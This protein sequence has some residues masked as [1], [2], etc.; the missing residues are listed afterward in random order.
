MNI[1]I[2]KTGLFAHVRRLSISLLACSTIVIP[3]PH[4]A[5]GPI[6]PAI[7]SAGVALN[8]PCIPHWP[9][10][11]ADFTTISKTRL[12][13]VVNEK[14][15]VSQSKLDA[16]SG[17]SALDDAVL[18]A[19]AKCKFAPVVQEGV[20]VKHSFLIRHTWVPGQTPAPLRARATC[21]KPRYPEAAR[22]RDQQGT[23][24]MM[25]LISSDGSV[26]DAKITQSSGFPLLDE[27]A[28]SSIARCPFEAGMTDGKPEQ[29]WVKLQYVWTLQ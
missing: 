2:I 25:F 29:S 9:A 1:R 22:R 21:E 6:D 5:A 26:Q 20:P 14:G 15:E 27:A 19:V 17:H 7:A 12:T 18:T 4:V 24:A 3:G 13:V 8:E 16:S 28:I 23:V 11:N 10:M